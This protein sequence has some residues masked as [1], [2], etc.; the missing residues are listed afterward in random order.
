M[1]VRLLSSSILR[2]PDQKRVDREVR[3]WA[4]GLTGRD[5]NVSR[6][7]YTGSYARG[8]WAMGSDV[9]LVVVLLAVKEPFM[10]RACRFDATDLSVPA[11]VLVYS[12][13]E[14]MGLIEQGRAPHPVVWID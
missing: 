11:D 12:E 13:T 2:W 10:E 4:R 9:D 3:D 6:V 1:P 7:G 8:N 14:W 5:P